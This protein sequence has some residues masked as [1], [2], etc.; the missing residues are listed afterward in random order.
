MRSDAE[1]KIKT[2]FVLADIAYSW[3]K[4]EVTDADIDAEVKN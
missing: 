2:S 4:L 1:N 3:K